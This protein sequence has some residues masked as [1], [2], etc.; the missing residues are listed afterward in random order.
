LLNTDDVKIYVYGKAAIVSGHSTRKYPDKD[1]FEIRYTA[2]YAK[3]QGRWQTVAFHSSIL[4][5]K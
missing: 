1:I 4:P 2:F 3:Q 5:A